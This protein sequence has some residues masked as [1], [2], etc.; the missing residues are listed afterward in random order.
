M[1]MHIFDCLSLSIASWAKKEPFLH[2]YCHFDSN[3]PCGFSRSVQ[4]EQLLEWFLSSFSLVCTQ[5]LL[6]SL[7]LRQHLILNLFGPEVVDLPLHMLQGVL[8]KDHFLFLGQ[9]ELPGFIF[10]THCVNVNNTPLY[11]FMNPFQTFYVTTICHV[12]QVQ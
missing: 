11:C 12:L 7:P 8:A 4:A 1:W 10:R 3:E 6:L 2:F 9:D 5:W